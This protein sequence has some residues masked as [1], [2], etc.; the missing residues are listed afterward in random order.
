M[1]NGTRKQVVRVM[2]AFDD[3]TTRVYPDDTGYMPVALFWGDGAGSGIDIVGKY[4]D[5]LAALGTPRIMAHTDLVSKFCT[6][7]ADA[8]CPSGSSIPLDHTVI[9][10]IWKT[11]CNPLI[12]LISKDPGCDIGG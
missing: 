1:S 4:Y 9:D 7:I 6:P 5:A 3:G 11:P 12:G 2:V 8:V 10:T